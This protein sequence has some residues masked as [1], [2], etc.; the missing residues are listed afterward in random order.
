MSSQVKAIPQAI[1]IDVAPAG[2]SEITVTTTADP[3][4][5]ERLERFWETVHGLIFDERKTMAYKGDILR[6]YAR[7]LGKRGEGEMSDYA[8]RLA[9][10]YGEVLGAIAHW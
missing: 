6:R 1:Q 4:R 10:S 3:I 2:L 7:A 8:S 9:G 5:D